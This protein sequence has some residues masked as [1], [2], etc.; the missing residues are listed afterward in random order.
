MWWASALIPP[1]KRVA[2]I[3]APLFF[4]DSSD[5][6]T[7]TPEPSP[8]TKPSRSLS[9]GR[10]AFSGSSFLLEIA[11]AVLKAQMFKSVTDPSHHQ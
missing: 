9:Q 3:F 5:S 11:W 2:K 6:I 10:E 4:A 7:K 1:P 8:K